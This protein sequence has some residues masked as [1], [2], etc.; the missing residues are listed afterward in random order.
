VIETFADSGRAPRRAD[1]DRSARGRGADPD[2]VLAEP[3][4]WDLIALGAHGERRAAYLF[5]PAPTPSQVTWDGSR[6]SYAMCAI[7]ALGMS[8]MLSRQVTIA[9]AEPDSGCVI[10]VEA[11]R[12]RARWRPRTAVVFAGAAGDAC[13][14][15]VDR[16][17]G[18]ISFFT[19]P[20]RTRLGG[21]PP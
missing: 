10:W 6:A 12:D 20:G 15:W 13:Q 1:L 3:A 5:S 11:D 7:A 16:C 17:C 8:A 4:E 9:A 2:A 21:P 14:A 19:A 18:Y